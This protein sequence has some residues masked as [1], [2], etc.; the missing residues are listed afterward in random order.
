[1]ECTKNRPSAHPFQANILF[2]Y[3]LKT[4]E[5]AV[6]VAKTYSAWTVK[7]LRYC[8]FKVSSKNTGKTSVMDSLSKENLQL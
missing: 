3:P 4:S 6:W 8:L 2:L 7:Q 5:T 1:M